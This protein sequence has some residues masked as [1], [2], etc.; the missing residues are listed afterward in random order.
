MEIS[1]QQRLNDLLIAAVKAG[2]AETVILLLQQ[3]ADPNAVAEVSLYGW[4]SS[5]L[6]ALE[7]ALT[8][9]YRKEAWE[10]WL[11]GHDE[12]EISIPIVKALVEAGADV[13]TAAS[14]VSQSPLVLAAESDQR[15]IAEYLLDHGADMHQIGYL[16][17]TPLCAA[18]DYRSLSVVQLLLERGSDPNQAC[19]G[20]TPLQRLRE[21]DRLLSFPL[22][23]EEKEKIEA[24]AREAA[25]AANARIKERLE[26]YPDPEY[27]LKYEQSWEDRNAATEGIIRLLKEY[28]AEE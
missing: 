9:H 4:D 15:E 24:K 2:D 23:P 19:R 17:E 26:K 28:G 18:V 7:L 6:P 5:K 25:R 3:G 12:E 8:W 27:E 20:F 22:P 16:R 1:E 10:L 11:A 14:D 21:A 13:N